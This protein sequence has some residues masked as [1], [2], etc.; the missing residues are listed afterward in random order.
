[1]KSNKFTLIAIVVVSSLV[2]AGCVK[3]DDAG[4]GAAG[5]K[6][7][8]KSGVS[9][10]CKMSTTE[11][12]T[13]EI[14]TKG[15]K[16]KTYGL[17]M[18]GGMGMGYTISDG[19]WLY[20]WVE[21]ATTGKKYPVVDEET[22]RSEGEEEPGE[23]PNLTAQQ[24]LEGSMVQDYEYECNE[25]D[26]PDSMFVPPA[27]VTFVDAVEQMGITK[28]QWGGTGGDAGGSSGGSS[29]EDFKQ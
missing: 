15:E 28:E 8:V 7:G 17:N 27:G 16:T 6:S 9:T 18:G 20:M 19:E 24:E 11:G 13:M 12:G 2:F 21:G 14:W 1:M 10:Y 29:L 23:M 5:S 26:I 4:S 25:Q 3:K 22:P